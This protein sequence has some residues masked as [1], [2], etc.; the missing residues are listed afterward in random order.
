MNLILLDD[1]DFV[2]GASVRLMGRRLK[3][4]REVHQPAVGDELTVGRLGGLIGKGRITKATSVAVEME[5][6]LRAAPPAPLAVNLVLALPRPKVIKRV[7][8][9]AA[10]SGC[11][12]SSAHNPLIAAFWMPVSVLLRILLYQYT[13]SGR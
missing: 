8:L 6:A 3:H 7:L 5:V 2:S 1:D 12:R 13:L 11:V 10:K 9:S 4:I